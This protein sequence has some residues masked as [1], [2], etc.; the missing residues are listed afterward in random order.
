MALIAATITDE[1]GP[2]SYG[3]RLVPVA[4]YELL[5][6][7]LWLEPVL[8]VAVSAA[9]MHSNPLE[10]GTYLVLLGGAGPYLPYFVSNGLRGTFVV[11]DSDA[12]EQCPN[13]G[14]PSHPTVV[15]KGVTDIAELT[16]LFAT[17]LPQT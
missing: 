16:A 7:Q 11:E 12:F 4:S 9:S 5:A 17:A 2:V 15:H 6:G 14:D 10:P 1:A 8:A 13:Y 3:E